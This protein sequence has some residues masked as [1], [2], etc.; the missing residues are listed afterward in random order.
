MRLS[1]II[2]AIAVGMAVVAAPTAAGAALS[3][4][5][6]PPTSPPGPTQPPPYPP[7][8]PTLTVNPSTVVEGETT[9]VTGTGFG[10][11]E[12]VEI[13]ITFSPLAAGALNSER[14]ARLD[15][16]GTVALAS[17]VR[18]RQDASQ[19]G[20]GPPEHRGGTWDGSRDCGE[21]TFTVRADA[22]GSFS[23]PYRAWCAGR[24]T[25]TARGLETGRTATAVLTVLPR[26]HGGKPP[27][28]G[29]KPPHHGGKL[30]V[31]GDDMELPI[32]V[33]GG[34]VGA[35]AVMLLGTFLWRRRSRFGSGA[36]S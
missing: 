6:P 1:R 27:H 29:G 11:N 34:L 25:F 22:Q 16:D 4:P 19:P 33:G 8:G 30:P 3:Q 2:T 23:F 26:H 28:H 10:P 20:D 17:V 36:A 13:T 35:G 31:T 9:T 24:V 5:Q 7:V 21:Q 32:K 18:Q 15:G 12:L 14:G